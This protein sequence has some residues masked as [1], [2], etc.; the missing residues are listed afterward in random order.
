MAGELGNPLA[1]RPTYLSS[2]DSQEGTRGEI[3]KIA[4]SLFNISNCLSCLWF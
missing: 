4:G 3:N 1:Y 2:Q